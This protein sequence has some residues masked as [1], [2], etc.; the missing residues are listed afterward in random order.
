[1]T[2]VDLDTPGTLNAQV[3]Y[4]ITGPA[5]A[6]AFFHID[7][8]SGN[9]TSRVSLTT[10]PRNLYTVCPSPPLPATSTRYFNY[11]QL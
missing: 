5:D 2:A 6:L 8:V 10:A 9:I 1:M 3:V 11:N 4:S 7:P